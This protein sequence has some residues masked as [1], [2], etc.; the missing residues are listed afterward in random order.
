MADRDG[1]CSRE[2]QM[3]MDVAVLVVPLF[4]WHIDYVNNV[5]LPLTIIL[6]FNMHT[7]HGLKLA[8]WPIYS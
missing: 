7:M 3:I 4:V 6:T 8:K 2:V 5:R 1:H